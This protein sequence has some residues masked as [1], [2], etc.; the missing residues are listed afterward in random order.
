MKEWLVLTRMINGRKVTWGFKGELKA[1]ARVE[2]TE[3]I[4]F[5]G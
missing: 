2:E 5:S 4:K 3:I 1:V